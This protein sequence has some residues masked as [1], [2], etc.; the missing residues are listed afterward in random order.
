MNEVRF[1]V[2][3]AEN[4]SNYVVFLNRALERLELPISLV[5]VED[6]EE[7]VAYLGG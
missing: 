5:V 1:V 3:L 7:A 4:D 6:G 2:L